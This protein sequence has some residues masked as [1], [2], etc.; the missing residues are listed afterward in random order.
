VSVV[1]RGLESPLETLFPGGSPDL[2][3]NLYERSATMRYINGLAASAF[4]SLTAGGALRILE[5]G[6]GTGGTTASLL[7]M[8]VPDRAQYVFTD[9]SGLF[10]DRARERFAAYPF[11][12]YRLFDMERDP[13]EQGFA[14]G[15]FD[16]I[17]SANAIHASTDL[18]L[19]LRRVRELL[20]PGGVLVLVE[21]TVHMDWF[22]MTTGLIEGWQHFADDLRTDNPLL[23]PEKWQVALRDAGFAAADT[24]PR[25]NSPATAL[26]QHLVIGLAPGEV[27][28]RHSSA[29]LDKADSSP[30]VAP[31]AVA[32]EEA[33]A[34]RQRVL[35]ALP[36]ERLELLRDFVR[37]QVVRVLKLDAT[38]P[39]GRHDR[40]MDLGL[41]SLMAVQLRN[42]LAKGLGE[43]R[44]LPATIMFDQPTIEALAAYL[45]ERITPA[46]QETGTSAAGKASA[47]VP[48]AAM[49]G[50]A[51]VAA[52]SDEQIEALLLERLGKA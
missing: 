39:P 16:I 25:G 13:A 47:P 2:A 30:S 9:M 10:L 43:S 5:I 44:P 33:E 46:A 27:V 37:S 49:L 1:L 41:D 11:V 23:A 26:G 32:A 22:D 14:A 42:Q 50:E 34:F 38:E 19:A 28:G 40:L 29:V 12:D 15:S 18:R 4:G 8:L 20:A 48:G 35:D 51:A 52:M 6:A 31:G 21:S 17:V 24:F 45:L 36:G 7:P 3:R